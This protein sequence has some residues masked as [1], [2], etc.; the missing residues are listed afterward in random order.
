MGWTLSTTPKLRFTIFNDW[1]DASPLADHTLTIA[2]YRYSF[3][4][5]Q[6]NTLFVRRIR[7]R[8]GQTQQTGCRLPLCKSSRINTDEK[9]NATLLLLYF[10]CKLSI[11]CHCHPL[12]RHFYA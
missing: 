2:L 10:C 5:L 8:Q 4:T 11:E 12:H 9:L 3:I 1:G 6:T 7:T